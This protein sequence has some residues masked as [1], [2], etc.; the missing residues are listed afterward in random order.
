[1]SIDKGA[2][3]GKPTGGG[4]C[5]CGCGGAAKVTEHNTKKTAVK[6]CLKS[7]FMRDKNKQKI[8]IETIK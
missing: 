3:I 5:G 4:A 1:M 2:S 8:T 6:K 7:L